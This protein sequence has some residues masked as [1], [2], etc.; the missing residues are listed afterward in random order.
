MA[1][2]CL[3]KVTHEVKEKTGAQVSLLLVESPLDCTAQTSRGS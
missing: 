1:V 2:G 3:T